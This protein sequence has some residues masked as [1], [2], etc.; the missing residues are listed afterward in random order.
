MSNGKPEISA[1]T[2]KKIIDHS[3]E[4]VTQGGQN[5]VQTGGHSASLQDMQQTV[6][7][8]VNAAAQE[9]PVAPTADM[10]QVNQPQVDQSMM[11][12]QKAEQPQQQQ[13]K[14]L[15]DLFVLGRIED[16]IGLAG[17]DFRM[18]SLRSDE[19]TDAFN[20]ASI[21]PPGEARDNAIRDNL[22]A[23][24]IVSV[25]G[26][27]LESLFPLAKPKDIDSNVS[28]VVKKLVVVG[29]FSQT[30]KMQLFSFYEKLMDRSI[31]AIGD[32]ATAEAL[33]N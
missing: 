22:L 33:K 11:Y 29:S 25:N 7:Q 1:Q 12:Q 23:R 5:N 14:S 24:S 9:K 26:E 21:Y 17:F 6:Q 31:E 13:P 3:I 4:D 28:D 8:T 19:T 18:H 15:K 10:P 16:T 32:P 2:Q 20:T 30:V 27:S